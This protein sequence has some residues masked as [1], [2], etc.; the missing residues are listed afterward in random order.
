MTE[1]LGDPLVAAMFAGIIGGVGLALI[2]QAGSTSGGTSQ[3]ARILYQKFEWNIILTTFIMDTII[4]FAGIFVIGPLYT[5]YTVISLAFGKVTSNYLP[6]IRRNC[7][8]S[9]RNYAIQCHLF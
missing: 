7:K 1:P 3:I 9:I 5:L 4:V 8:T 6:R 2:I